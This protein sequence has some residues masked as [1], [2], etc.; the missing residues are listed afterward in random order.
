MTHDGTDENFEG[1]ANAEFLC[2]AVNSHAQLV[3]ALK[4]LADAVNPAPNRQVAIRSDNP[5]MVKARAL[6]STLEESR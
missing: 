3:E 5:V 4:E 1:D 6:L 2:K